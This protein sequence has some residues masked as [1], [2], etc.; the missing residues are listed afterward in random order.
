MLP[1]APSRRALLALGA[2]LLLPRRAF[3]LGEA[4]EV[5][6]AE[7]VLPTGTSSTPDAWSGLLFELIQT[8]SVEAV[9]RAVQIAPDDPSLFQHPI[10]VLSGTGALPALSERAIEQLSRYL[11]YGGFLIANDSSGLMDSP[12]DRSLRELVRR[13]LPNRSLQ[14]LRSD[15]SVYRSF[16]LLNKPAGR[17][18]NYR[19]LEGVEVGTMHPLVYSR[20][21]LAGALD[22]YPDGTFRNPCTPD[23]ELQRREAVKTSINLIMYA[24]TSNY[25][26]D[27]A[28]AKELLRR[29]QLLRGAP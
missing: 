1:E 15:H 27:Q 20:D 28:H 3:A 22:R 29:Q 17:V 4:S 6:I 10:A 7:L 5:D 8:T 13:I 11:T 23:G 14:V 2:G 21:D 16:F 24:L 12:F 9:P 25:K 26:Q 19:T 18:A